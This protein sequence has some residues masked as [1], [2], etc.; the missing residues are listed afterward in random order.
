MNE[1]PRTICWFSCGAASAV[2]TKLALQ[3]RDNCEI[4]YQDTGAEHPDNKRFLKDCEQWFGQEIK[5]I[6]SERYDSVWD[7][8]EK[9]RY[10]VGVGG[11]R[12]TSEMKRIPAEK[13]INHLIDDE[14]FGYTVEEQHRVERFKEGNPERRIVTPLIEHQLGKS[15]CLGLIKQQ[16]IEL[17]VL[18]QQGFNNNNCIGCVKGGQGYWGR[19]RRLYPDVFERMSK[20]ERELNVAINK[21]YVDGERIRVFLDE[22]P[23][24]AEKK[25]KDPDMSCGLFC[26]GLDLGYENK[27]DPS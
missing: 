15:D 20:L 23:E 9:T 27:S 14:V 16:G 10:L 25:H 24:D 3:E 6:K 18:Y 17:P 26:V 7:V 5:T 11:A 8:F 19:I 13:Y 21:K 22:L 4:V 2:A 1:K 12:C